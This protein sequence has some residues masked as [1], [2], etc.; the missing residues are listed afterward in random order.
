MAPPS[1][2][3]S[4]FSL[5]SWLWGPYSVSER[6]TYV[7]MN[8]YLSLEFPVWFCNMIGLIFVIKE[9]MEQGLAHLISCCWLGNQTFAS[10][11]HSTSYFSSKLQGLCGVCTSNISLLWTRVYLLIKMCQPHPKLENPQFLSR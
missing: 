10:I 6:V 1:T 8:C 3:Y 9:Y 11:R 4:L 7:I 5:L 2:G